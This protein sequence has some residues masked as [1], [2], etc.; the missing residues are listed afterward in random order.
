LKSNKNKRLVL[1]IFGAALTVVDWA[2]AVW[3]GAKMSNVSEAVV[4]TILS[5]ILPQ[6]P[7]TVTRVA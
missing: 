5:F 3:G 1:Y 6:F 2:H 7:T 4:K